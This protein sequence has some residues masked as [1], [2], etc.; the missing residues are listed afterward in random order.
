MGKVAD[1]SPTTTAK[2]PG[3]H[4]DKLPRLCAAINELELEP[5]RSE[6]G[7][8]TARLPLGTEPT[9]DH[10]QQVIDYIS[11]LLEDDDQWAQVWDTPAGR[12][13][14]GED[15]SPEEKWAKMM[16]ELFLGSAYMGPD[17]LASFPSAAQLGGSTIAYI[18]TRFEPESSTADPDNPG[19]FRS[20]PNTDPAH[21]IG[22]ACQ[23]LTTYAVLSRGFSLDED[24]GRLGIP[25]SQQALGVPLYQSLGAGRWFTDGPVEM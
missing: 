1:P 9:L 22:V 13:P 10:V 11:T 15:D 4:A 23:N 8:N 2:D 24:L 6:A 7:D 16:D 5:D 20:T 19:E 21:S 17:I 18:Y 25:A 3:A 14:A 12:H